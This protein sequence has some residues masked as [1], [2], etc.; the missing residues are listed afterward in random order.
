MSAGA[1]VEGRMFEVKTSGARPE[2]VQGV[3]EPSV[4]EYG[5][6]EFRN[7]AGQVVAIF[8]RHTWLHAVE[9]QVAADDGEGEGDG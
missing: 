2:Y 3:R 9:L 6:L 1:A 5:E 4:T 8:A 7:A